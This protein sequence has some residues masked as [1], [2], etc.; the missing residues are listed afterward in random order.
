MDFLVV[1]VFP[2]TLD[3]EALTFSPLEGG[4]EAL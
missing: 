3:R 1:K 2:A 4:P